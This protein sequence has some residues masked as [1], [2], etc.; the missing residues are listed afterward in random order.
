MKERKNLT[1]S[2]QI[3]DTLS[4]KEKLNLNANVVERNFAFILSL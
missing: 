1:A 4:C 2:I 3:C